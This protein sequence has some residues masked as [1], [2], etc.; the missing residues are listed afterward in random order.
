MKKKYL[1]SLGMAFFGMGV[2]GCS[3]NSTTTTND[4]TMQQQ[5]IA[6][7]GFTIDIDLLAGTYAMMPNISASDLL[8]AAAVPNT[9]VYG[10]YEGDGTKTD[11]VMADSKGSFTIMA[12]SGT[13]LHMVAA[14]SGAV[15]NTYTAEATTV[16]TTAVMGT[17]A[18][19]CTSN[20]YAAP[21]GVAAATGVAV[22]QIQD[23]GICMFGTNDHFTAPFV[24][25]TP[26]QVTTTTTGFDVWAMTDPRP[27]PVPTFVKQADSPIGIHAIFKAGNTAETQVA[28]TST[29]DSPSTNT[30][31]VAMCDVKPGFI[32]FMPIDP[33]N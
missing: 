25:L 17:P 10:L 6:V 8:A 11:Q 21:A 33:T 29:A 19:V 9:P 22:D 3:D 18:H 23:A 27:M 20:P 15:L 4:M 16:G 26:S 13:K 12:K 5:M 28:L 31:A 24:K 30:F 14:A 32:T 1:L 2:M 7:S